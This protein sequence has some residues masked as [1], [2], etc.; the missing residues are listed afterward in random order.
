MSFQNQTI[1][2]GVLETDLSGEDHFIYCHQFLGHEDLGMTVGNFALEFDVNAF[3]KCDFEQRSMES[4]ASYLEG[5]VAGRWDD[6]SIKNGI[7]AYF[8]TE[9]GELDERFRPLSRDEMKD[10]L[11]SQRFPGYL[12]PHLLQEDDTS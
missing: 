8:Y 6:I 7:P 1:Y 10:L 11:E 2:V 9:N 12:Y 5:A 3:G 4:L